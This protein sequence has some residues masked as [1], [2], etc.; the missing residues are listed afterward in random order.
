VAEGEGSRTERGLQAADRIG[1]DDR[2]PTL[3]WLAGSHP[4]DPGPP[5]DVCRFL[6]TETP[7]GSFGPASGDVDGRHRCVALGDAAPQSARQQ[8]LVCLATAHRNCPRYLRGVL[9]EDAPPPPPAREPVSA[10]VV[11]SALIL[12]AAIAA[13]F[14][15]LA[16]RGGLTVALASPSPGSSQIALVPAASITPISSP[17]PSP[18]PVATPAATPSP[19]PSPTPTPTPSRSPTPEISAPPATPTP[20]PS[21]DRYAVLSPCP[22]TPDCW[23]YTVRPGDNLVSIAHWFGVSLDA[24]YEM[25]PWARTTGLR[26]GQELRL[27][28]PTR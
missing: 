24:I 7:D 2:S 5:P 10:A 27:P 11:A 23:I 4:P 6:A 20:R 3:P 26:A 14:G 16:V 18:T 25:N 19:S 17:S 21:S 9:L 12:V 15:F 8:Q 22:S 13:S 1:D 28:P